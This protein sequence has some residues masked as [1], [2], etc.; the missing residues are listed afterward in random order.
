[1]DEHIPYTPGTSK[2]LIKAGLRHGAP[3]FQEWLLHSAAFLYFSMSTF[4]PTPDKSLKIRP[5]NLWTMPQ[6]IKH[7]TRGQDCQ[8]MP[9]LSLLSTSQGTPQIIVQQ[10]LVFRLEMSV[11]PRLL[12]PE[13]VAKGHVFAG[14]PYSETYLKPHY[15]LKRTWWT[16]L[17]VV[18]Q[19]SLW[20]LQQVS[21]CQAS[22]MLFLPQLLRGVDSVISTC[23]MCQRDQRARAKH[24]SMLKRSFITAPWL[25]CSGRDFCS[26]EHLNQTLRQCQ[27]CAGTQAR[28]AAVPGW[29]SVFSQPWELHSHSCQEKKKQYEVLE[30]WT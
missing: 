11:S 18:S 28:A 19:L 30:V 3:D 20:I 9:W 4:Q 22:S 27:Q 26:I 24:G 2:S 7:G 10:L 23:G 14:V 8:E 15:Q 6:P 13:W 21:K 29:V 17:S 25:H 1:M 5:V 16:S 12:S